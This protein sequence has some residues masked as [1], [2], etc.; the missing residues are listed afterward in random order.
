[1]TKKELKKELKKAQKELFNI[2]FEIVS[3]KVENALLHRKN[4]ALAAENE[5]LKLERE[6]DNAFLED[7]EERMIKKDA[8]IEHYENKFQYKGRK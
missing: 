8:V 3:K 6:I 7:S 4:D 1:M 2:G 5:N